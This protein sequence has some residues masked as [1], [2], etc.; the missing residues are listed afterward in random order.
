MSNICILKYNNYINREIKK[1]FNTIQEYTQ[2]IGPEDAQAY[3]NLNFYSIDGVS[4]QQLITAQ[5]EDELAILNKSDYLIEYNDDYSVKS[6]WFIIDKERKRKNQHNLILKRDSITDKLDGTLNAKAFI[7]KGYVDYGNSLFFNKENVAVNQVKKNE[8]LLRDQTMNP[9]VV[10]YL[11]QNIGNDTYNGTMRGVNYTYNGWGPFSG[12]IS[13]AGTVN[14]VVLDSE[15][16]VTIYNTNSYLITWDNFIDYWYPLAGRYERT[17]EDFSGPG[18]FTW[19]VT[20]TLGHFINQDSITATSKAVLLQNNTYKNCGA[21]EESAI[22]KVGSNYYRVTLAKTGDVQFDTYNP[23]LMNEIKNKYV[24]D[25][26]TI[27]S[28][29][30][31]GFVR[32]NYPV[33]QLKSELIPASETTNISIFVNNIAQDAPNLTDAPYKM[34]CFPLANVNQIKN[35]AGQVEVSNLNKERILQCLT[36]LTEGFGSNLYDLQILPYC[37]VMN[38]ISNLQVFSDYSISFQFNGLMQPVWIGGTQNKILNLLWCEQSVFNVELRNPVKLNVVGENPID[39]KVSNE[40][41]TWRV[42]SPNYSGTFEF[43]PVRNGGVYGWN[44]DCA[45]KPYTPHIHVA[46]KFNMLYGSDFDDARGLICSGDFSLPRITSQWAEYEINNKNYQLQFNREIQ[47]M[48]LQQN[49]GI[50]ESVVNATLGSAAKGIGAGAMTGNPVAGIGMAGVSAV[51]GVLNTVEQAVLGNDK[52]NA[53]KDQFEFNIQNIK[54]RPYSL[55]NIGVLNKDYKYFPFVEMWS[56]PEADKNAVKEKLIE[57]GM[58][59]N[60]IGTIMEYLGQESKSN[61]TQY[62]QAQ[63]IRIDIDDDYHLAN[64]INNELMRGV[65][66]YGI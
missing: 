51:E 63:L 38:R 34:F 62:I 7:Y 45:Y 8:Y 40:V 6:R 21:A 12:L 65:K 14:N 3:S 57:S 26:P 22:C 36:A 23:T 55:T 61:F 2:S 18:S 20:K 39:L 11:A 58:T 52:I 30:G 24:E 44:V 53:A 35:G 29:T 37:P 5:D 33:Y 42:V 9:W 66:I 56:A 43:T 16:K 48:E 1:R 27:M 46:P 50:A 13:G 64:D 31:G 59:I 54:A 60:S 15:L 28:T 25:T 10:G 41:M 4:A 17:E 49:W 47:S 32:V 19:E